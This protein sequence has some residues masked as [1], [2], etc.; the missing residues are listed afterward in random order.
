MSASKEF[1]PKRL[2]METLCQ[3]LTGVNFLMYGEYM[4]IQIIT[5]SQPEAD[6]KAV[7]S[8]FQKVWV[9]WFSSRRNNSTGINLWMVLDNLNKSFSPRA[10]RVTDVIG[11][12]C[13]ALFSSSEGAD[14][15]IRGMDPALANL[16]HASTETNFKELINLTE[17]PRWSWLFAKR[18]F[19]D[20][21]HFHLLR[22]MIGK[23]IA[24]SLWQAPWLFCMLLGLCVFTLGM[25]KDH[26]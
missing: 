20:P 26:C 12:A 10:V 14:M 11:T 24:D 5:E 17:R 22:A 15:I 18:R 21:L 25:L 3:D 7:I 23:E 13:S 2:K 8:S 1:S 9:I 6:W 4:K 19:I 16:R